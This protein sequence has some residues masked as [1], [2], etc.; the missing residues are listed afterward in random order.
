MK[1][2]EALQAIVGN[3]TTGESTNL[4][5]FRGQDTEFGIRGT[6]Y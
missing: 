1:P 3:P 6:P 4:G 5:E 2:F